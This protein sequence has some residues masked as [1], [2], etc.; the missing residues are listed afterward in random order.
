MPAFFAA[1]TIGSKA[2]RLTE[3]DSFSSSSKLAS[4]DIQAR[5]TKASWPLAVSPSRAALRISPLTIFKF[6]LFFGRKSLSKN[7]ASNTV[8]V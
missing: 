5:L 6:G 7:I 1:I 4:L 3:V 8:T 2:S